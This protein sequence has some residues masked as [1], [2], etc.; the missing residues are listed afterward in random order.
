VVCIAA[1]GRTKIGSGL[2]TR[3]LGLLGMLPGPLLPGEDQDLGLAATTPLLL[4]A[5]IVTPGTT[6]F[7]FALQTKCL[8]DL[9]NIQPFTWCLS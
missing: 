6:Y 7:A 1:G 5:L 3:G 2:G 4:S 8:S 9:K